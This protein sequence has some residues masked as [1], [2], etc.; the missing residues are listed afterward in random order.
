M[1]KKSDITQS[2]PPVVQKVSSNLQR[3]GFIGFWLQLILGIIS[4]V[5]LFFSTPA[6]FNSKENNPA[7]QFGILCAFLSII[8]L[9]IAIFGFY[10][11]YKR[12]GKQIENRDPKQ[13]P[14]K[15][16]T[17][18]LIKV[19]LIMNVIGLLLAIIGA[20]A[21]VGIALGKSLSL[22]PQLIGPN[23]ENYVNSLDLLIIQANTNTIT[24]HFAGIVSSLLLLNRITS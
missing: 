11:R 6:L 20:E 24:A 16:D 2:L 9:A 7:N 8:F 19:G 21:L 10:F 1:T 14:K 22:A 18:Q 5:T 17:L 13:R 3:W 15:A 4:I 23:P 12:L